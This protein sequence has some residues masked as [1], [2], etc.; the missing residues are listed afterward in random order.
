MKNNK[1]YNFMINNFIISK[2]KFKILKTFFD[3][4]VIKLCRENAELI[5]DVCEFLHEQNMT[6]HQWNFYNKKYALEFLHQYIDAP[7]NNVETYGYETLFWFYD[8]NFSENFKIT[9]YLSDI[10]KH[11][12]SGVFED[13][14]LFDFLNSDIRDYYFTREMFEECKQLAVSDDAFIDIRN[15]TRPDMKLKTIKSIDLCEKFENY[16]IFHN[17]K[18]FVAV[19]TYDDARN[20]AIHNN[21]FYF[22]KPGIKPHLLDAYQEIID[23]FEFPE[24]YD[25][26]MFKNDDDCFFLHNDGI[27]E[28][29][30]Y[31][32]LTYNNEIFPRIYSLNGNIPRNKSVEYYRFLI[33]VDI[34]RENMRTTPN[35]KHHFDKKYYFRNFLKIGD[36]YVFPTNTNFYIYN[37]NNIYQYKLFTGTKATLDDVFKLISDNDYKFEVVI[38]KNHKNNIYKHNL[39]K[40][41]YDTINTTRRKDD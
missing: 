34:F 26:Y 24:K 27:I 3:N 11:K 6:K 9:K 28:K 39:L 41:A 32:N 38:D 40:Y 20:L 30:R 33:Y 5:Y 16:E 19:L 31:D 13:L 23:K 36:K 7:H 4:P 17:N 29:T 35:F 15:Y 10:Y 18:I 12:I 25:K 8:F 22:S 2:N 37:E 21:C 1:T 14:S